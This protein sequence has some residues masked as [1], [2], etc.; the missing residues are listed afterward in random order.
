LLWNASHFPSGDQAAL[1][2]CA[3]L[4]VIWVAPVPLAFITNTS[5]SP[6]R[7][8]LKAIF[9]PSGDHAGAPSNQ[10]PFVKRTTPVPSGLT[11]QM[12]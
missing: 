11:D 12:L 7:S 10:A 1:P 9:L 3:V 2:S 6:S 4:N 8:L 5:L